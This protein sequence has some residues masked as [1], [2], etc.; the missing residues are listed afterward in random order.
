MLSTEEITRGCKMTKQHTVQ[1]DMTEFY[2]PQ[3]TEGLC[4]GDLWDHLMTDGILLFDYSGN[5]TT[6][7]NQVTDYFAEI[8]KQVFS[9]GG[10]FKDPLLVYHR[11]TTS[12]WIKAVL[13]YYWAGDPDKNFVLLSPN[14]FVGYGYQ[15]W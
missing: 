14:S 3:N 9:H 4:F 5:D 11:G 2:M 13:Q 8:E 10:S 15:A 12:A 7:L 1:V 6:P